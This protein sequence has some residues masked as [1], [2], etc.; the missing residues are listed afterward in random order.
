MSAYCFGAVEL[1]MHSYFIKDHLLKLK[2][3]PFLM[4]N[5]SYYTAM[6]SKM[7]SKNDFDLYLE[8]IYQFVL[9]YIPFSLL[10]N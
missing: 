10:Q 5:E 6:D 7:Q 8:V 2:N 4:T 3:M 1:V 9:Y